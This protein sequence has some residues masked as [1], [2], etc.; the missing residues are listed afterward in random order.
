MGLAKLFGFE[1]KQTVRW[2]GSITELD[3]T[4]VYSTK[5]VTKFKLESLEKELREGIGRRDFGDKEFQEVILKLIQTL[6]ENM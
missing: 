3:P 1:Q 4:R 6:K 5:E 2:A